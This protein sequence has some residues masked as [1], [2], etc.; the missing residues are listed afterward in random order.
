VL[1]QL[2]KRF[3]RIS[4]VQSA[5]AGQLVVVVRWSRRPAQLPSP[6]KQAAAAVHAAT[7]HHGATHEQQDQ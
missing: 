6:A 1:T 7:Y 2:A 4:D 3:L 5:L